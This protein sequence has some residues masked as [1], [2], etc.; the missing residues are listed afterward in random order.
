MNNR[1][2]NNT[3]FNNSYKIIN[4]SKVNNRSLVILSKK[5]DFIINEN[6]NNDTSQI[7]KNENNKKS[8]TIV[9]NNKKIFNLKNKENENKE[10]DMKAKKKK[11]KLSSSQS[12]EILNT[13]IENYYKNK[14]K[15][16]VEEKENKKNN[17]GKVRITYSSSCDNKKIRTPLS[18]FRGPKVT[19][20]QHF[21]R[22]H[23]VNK[24]L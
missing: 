10:N 18:T 5:Q 21:N 9:K 23:T 1:N 2:T 20:F 3:Y 4:L 16:N 24:L 22:T 7:N 15:N 19:I 11:K 17:Q 12:I 13:I 6:E 8:D 14:N